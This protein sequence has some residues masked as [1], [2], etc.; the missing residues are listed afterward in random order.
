MPLIEIATIV[1]MSATAFVAT[2]LDNLLLL[3]GFHTAGTFVRRA[4]ALGY[5]V[6]IGIV[7]ALALGLAGAA[8]A[9]LPFSLGWLGLAPLSIGIWQ[10]IRA[11]QTQPEVA[12]DGPARELRP[13]DLTLGERA[14]GF[15]SILLTML[16][17]SG[18]SL[19]VVTA[20]LGDT[21]SNLDG[22]VVATL[23]GMGVLWTAGA[24]WLSL[25]PALQK[26]L[27]AFARFGLPLLLIA[28]GGYI[29]LD[30]PTD[31]VQ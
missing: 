18:D 30:T 17:N 7:A 27:R 5:L 20:L 9:T 15:L 23:L 25:R 31:I 28:V 16:A 6:A 14:T 24:R 1:A 26:P 10:G 12:L 11:F 22:C 2:S 3:V 19:V 29:L 4:I 13:E 21:R 8:E